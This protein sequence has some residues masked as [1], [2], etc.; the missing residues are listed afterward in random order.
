MPTAS[1]RTTSSNKAAL[2]QPALP[3]PADFLGEFKLQMEELN[4]HVGGCVEALEAIVAGA[5]DFATL[6]KC[7]TESAAAA[8]APRAGGVPR[9]P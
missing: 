4:T 2:R 6:A 5:D 3:G 7:V 8:R 9:R 1:S